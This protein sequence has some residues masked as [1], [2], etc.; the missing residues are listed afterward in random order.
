LILRLGDGDLTYH[1]VLAPSARRREEIVPV[2][3]PGRKDRKQ[4]AEGVTALPVGT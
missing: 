1:G 3:L 4:P 2:T